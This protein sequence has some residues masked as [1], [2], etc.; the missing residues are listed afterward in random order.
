MLGIDDIL[1]AAKVTWEAIARTAKNALD[2]IDIWDAAGGNK[3]SS[4]RFFRFFN[5]F[6]KQSPASTSQ[7]ITAA[8]HTSSF[9]A[10]QGKW[11]SELDPDEPL[12]RSLARPIPRQPDDYREGV[13]YRY[14]VETTLTWPDGSD[15]KVFHTYVYSRI[16]LTPSG[17]YSQAL[18]ILFEPWKSPT[19]PVDYGGEGVMPDVSQ[20]IG[21]F[22]SIGVEGA[23]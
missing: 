4:G 13:N 16:P 14:R 6:K 19:K 8:Y 10:N 21:E 1:A 18:E 23:S 20:K 9:W 12:L 15:P 22:V 7:D 2:Y 5:A 3:E 17:A 11:L